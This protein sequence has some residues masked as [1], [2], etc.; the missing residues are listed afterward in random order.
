MA[1]KW[2]ISG[3]YHE[4]CSCDYVCPCIL[5]N[6]AARPTKGECH[7]AMVY[8]IGRGRYEQ[9]TLDGVRFAVVGRTPDVM[10][11]GNW[12]VGVVVDEGATAEQVEAITAIASGQ[13]GGPMAALGP[14]VGTF[15]G[16]ER[17]PIQV[18]KSGLKRSASIPGVLDH[19]IEGVE[20]PS[21]PGEALGVDNTLHPANARLSLAH[22]VRSVLTVFGLKWED[23]SGKN[24]GHFAPFSWA[25]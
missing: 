2:Q 20:S 24:N 11:A 6:L 12:S 3:D 13:A 25:A 1:A 7:F 9:V 19:A 18:T 15:L 21:K 22:A 23:R 14:L 16:V 5:T 17:K 10:G 4:T 8:E